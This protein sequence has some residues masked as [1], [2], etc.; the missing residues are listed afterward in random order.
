MAVRTAVTHCQ[1][2]NNLHNYCTPLRTTDTSDY[3][4]FKHAAAK[5][6]SKP[7]TNSLE[8]DSLATKK[9]NHTCRLITPCKRLEM[10]KI[11]S[12]NWPT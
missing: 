8:Q 11:L 4:G 12:Y 5:Y 2:F 1:S 3:S 6:S 7:E 10:T 9:H